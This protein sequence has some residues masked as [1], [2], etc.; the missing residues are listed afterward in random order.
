VA[1]YIWLTELCE[2]FRK[3]DR[4][5]MQREVEAERAVW[6]ERFAV[7]LGDAGYGEAAAF[8]R[9]MAARP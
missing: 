5:E 1:Q 7:L 9:G 3:E 6:A 2:K 8:L 4:E